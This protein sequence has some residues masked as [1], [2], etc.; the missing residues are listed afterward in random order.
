LSEKFVKRIIP[1]NP[2][3]SDQRKSPEVAQKFWKEKKFLLVGKSGALY[4]ERQ[5]PLSREIGARLAQDSKLEILW[6]EAAKRT[7]L[8][9]EGG[10]SSRLKKRAE[11]NFSKKE[12]GTGDTPEEE[13][14]CFERTLGRTEKKRSGGGKCSSGEGVG[15][16]CRGP[17][18]KGSFKKKKVGKS[19]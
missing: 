9:S 5:E 4:T 11:S 18:R 6:P 12:G 13:S 17:P 10:L 7:S 8:Q 16:K 19:L 3:A 1:R 2:Q 14:T 15:L